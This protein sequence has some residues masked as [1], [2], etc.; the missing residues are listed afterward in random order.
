VDFDADAL[1]LALCSLLVLTDPLRD[2]LA[3]SDSAF[4]LALADALT[5]A[6]VLAN[7]EVDVL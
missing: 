5:T 7:F 1:W 2:L 6:L 4:W 3:R